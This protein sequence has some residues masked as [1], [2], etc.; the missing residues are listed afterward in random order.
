VSPPRR[1]LWTALRVLGT[2][3]ALGWLVHRVDLRAAARAALLVPAP[4][5]VLPITLMTI[6][7]AIHGWRWSLLLGAAGAPVG[8]VH[9]TGIGLR[10]SF[11][12]AVSPSGGADLARVAWL[13]AH[14]GRPDA[15][16][17]AMLVARLL[18]LVPWAAL[19]G[20]GLLGALDGRWPA[21]QAAAAAALGAFGVT[22]IVGALIVRRGAALAGRLRWLQAPALRVA[23]ALD[24]LRHAPGRLA[25]ATGL[26]GVAALHNVL[27][28]WSLLRA[29][30]P[31]GQA[32]AFGLALGL[33]PAMD[34]V[35]S[36][37]VTIN[38]VGL[39]EAV[40]LLAAT[41]L[42]IPEATA[43]GLALVRWSGELGRA[44]LGGA[45]VAF[46]DR[47]GAPSAAEEPPR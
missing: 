15:V 28:V 41:P 19:L 11:V 46:G 14:T 33:V 30:A 25:L 5:L 43:L 36:L 13:S 39:R 32:P 29:A 45:L 12:G 42:G 37:P 6:N 16:V 22:L 9:C 47:G 18:E 24:R 17:A 27:S 31:P 44:L 35:I 21:L 4:V 2:A 8:W 23:G 26:A 10:A 1:R 40:F 3:A 20:W 38:G 34:A 7:T